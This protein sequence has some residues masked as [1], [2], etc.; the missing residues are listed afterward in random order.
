MM[1]MPSLAAQLYAWH[2]MAMTGGDAIRHDGLPEAGWYR[3]RLVRGGPWAPVEII[4]E[5][6]IDDETGE[7]TEPERLVALVG[8]PGMGAV[9]QT[10]RD[11]ASLWLHLNP[12]SKADYLALL[13]TPPQIAAMQAVN[14]KLDLTETPICP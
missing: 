7:L 12:I 14:A 5:R 9:G 11:P 8:I 6:T 3:T 10:R 13:N 4:V 2:R 1:R